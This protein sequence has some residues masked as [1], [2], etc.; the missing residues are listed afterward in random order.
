MDEFSAGYICDRTILRWTSRWV[1]GGAGTTLHQL[2]DSPR[3]TAPQAGPD[4]CGH[5]LS[6]KPQP[7]LAAA[8]AA[9]GAPPS[10][11]QRRRLRPPP[12][13]TPPPP[14]LDARLMR[15]DTSAHA[16]ASHGE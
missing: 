13:D 11:L 15:T 3:A 1:S 14:P 4:S 8:E 12:P 7:G 9:V 10:P 16:A 2:P 6:N 5:S